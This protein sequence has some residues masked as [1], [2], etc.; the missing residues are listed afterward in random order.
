MVLAKTTH[1][2][3]VR[4]LQHMLLLQATATCNWWQAVKSSS[5]QLFGVHLLPLNAFMSSGTESSDPRDGL[6]IVPLGHCLPGLKQL[7]RAPVHSYHK[8]TQQQLGFR[9]SSCVSQ[10]LL[11]C[12]K[13]GNAQLSRSVWQCVSCCILKCFSICINIH[14]RPLPCLLLERTLILVS[15]SWQTLFW[16]LIVGLNT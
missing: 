5:L 8:K 10:V 14:Y 9:G 3:N 11:N 1:S 15:N 13:W 16:H 12:P 7:R 4:E 2:S 6:K